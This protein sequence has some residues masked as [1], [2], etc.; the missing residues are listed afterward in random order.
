MAATFDLHRLLERTDVYGRAAGASEATLAAMRDMLAS[1]LAA[2]LLALT[3]DELH[4]VLV[5]DAYKIKMHQMYAKYFQGAHARAPSWWPHAPRT[6]LPLHQA[7]SQ[8][9]T[10]RSSAPAQASRRTLRSTSGAR[11][12]RWSRSSSSTRSSGPSSSGTWRSC[13]PRARCPRWCWM[14]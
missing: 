3:E 4:S 2:R 5:N 6:T 11:P 9:S 12:R 1:P 14:R 10:T 13:R 7:C 8:P